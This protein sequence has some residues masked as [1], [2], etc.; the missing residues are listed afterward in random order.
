MVSS[1]NEGNKI[2]SNKNEYDT[3]IKN[4]AVEEKI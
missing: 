4:N 3:A 1:R 2:W